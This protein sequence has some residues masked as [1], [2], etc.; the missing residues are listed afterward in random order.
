MIV[1]LALSLLLKFKTKIF[2]FVARF[3]FAILTVVIVF[4]ITVFWILYPL[5]TSGFLGRGSDR[6]E[7]LNIAF[8]EFI[9]GRYPYFATTHLGGKITPLLGSILIASP[10]ILLGNSAYR[11]L[12]WLG[13]FLL[14]KSIYLES[15][16]SAILMFMFLSILSPAFQYEYISGGDL[17]ANSIYVLVVIFLQ[18]KALFSNSMIAKIAT[19]LFTGIALAS[20]SNFLTLLPLMLILF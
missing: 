15:F 19:S 7:A 12:F 17:I 2:S 13:I 10:F 3:Y 18:T 20:R 9:Q 14:L 11:N 4:G 1:T 8:W 6:D 5:E 16:V